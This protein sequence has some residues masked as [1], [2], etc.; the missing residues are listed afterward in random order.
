MYVKYLEYYLAHIKQYEN[1]IYYYY[2]EESL[3]YQE[4]RLVYNERKLL[5]GTLNESGII[6]DTQ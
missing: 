6:L 2:S 4:T 3:S 5:S 1:V